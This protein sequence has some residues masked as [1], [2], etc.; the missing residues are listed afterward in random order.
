MKSEYRN[1]LAIGLSAL[2][3]VLWFSVINPPKKEAASQVAQT[4]VQ[5]QTQAVQQAPSTSV[6]LNTPVSVPSADPQ[7]SIPTKTWTLRNKLVEIDLTSDGAVPTSWR[8]LGF[9]QGTSNDSPLIDLV[10]DVKGLP[11]PLSLS[12]AGANFAFPE[13]PKFEMVSADDSR[14]SFKW[15]SK[16]VEVTKTIALAGD[17]YL[18]DVTVEVKNTAKRPLEGRALLSWSGARLPEKKWRSA[19]IS[20]ATVTRQQGSRLLHGWQGLSRRRYCENLC[21]D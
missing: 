21:P 4:Q 14:V 19:R 3:F 17:S 10:A 13:R 1:A 5:S 15:K 12:F 7:G 18:A 2:F 20:Q 16:D 6:P 11:P 8:I 9:H